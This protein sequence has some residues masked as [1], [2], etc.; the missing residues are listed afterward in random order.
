MAG[1]M[2]CL[3]TVLAMSISIGGCGEK[4]TVSGNDSGSQSTGNN[5]GLTAGNVDEEVLA[6]SK[7]A[8]KTYDG[9][10]FKFLYTWQP[11]E[12]TNRMVESFNMEHDANIEIVVNTASIYQT[13]ATAIASG[14]PYDMVCT[15][16]HRYPNIAV[17]G[18][19]EPLNDYYDEVDLY[20]S[21]KPNNGGLNKEFIDFYSLNGN[22]Y[23]V[24]SAKSV[25]QLMM[26]YNKKLFRDNGLE[27][28]WELYQSGKWNWDKFMEMAQAVT[29]TKNGMAFTAFGD[30]WNWINLNCVNIIGKDGDTF[31][32]RTTEK[33]VIEVV[34]EYQK[35]YLGENPICLREADMFNGTAFVNFVPTNSYSTYAEEAQAS[36]AFDRQA[37]NL[38]ACPV[39]ITSLNKNQLYPLH[40]AVGYGVCQGA[41]DPSV[42]VCYALFESRTTDTETGEAYQLNPDVYNEII[43]RYNEKPFL[44]YSGFTDSN[45][46]SVAEFYRDT[47]S[48]QNILEGADVVQ[49]LTKYQPNIRRMIS[50]SMAK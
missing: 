11:G 22:S 25:Y 42:A 18:L 47:I 1:K 27:D 31:K 12:I 50:D 4:D 40:A 28:P 43:A 21:A 44:S 14:T 24:G 29:D 19:L 26:I 2:L 15:Y 6:N 30:I 7:T 32:D 8:N 3:L 48:R 33:D 9:K 37:A 13:L 49:T 23:L 5:G 17:Q 34:Q 35:L 41:S 45:G 10:H 16:N 46:F 20:N 39:P 38:G 36:T